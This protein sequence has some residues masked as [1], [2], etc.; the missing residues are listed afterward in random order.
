M[1][2]EPIQ[3]W[4]AG[5]YAYPLALGYRP[6]MVPYLHEEDTPRPC[7]L[8]VPGGGYTNVS[9]SEGELVAKRFYEAGFQTFLCSY[10]TN[11]LY[12]QP[13][14]DQPMQDLARAIRLLRSRPEA[15]RIDPN[16]IAV[17]GFSAGAHLCASVCVHSDEIP[18][19]R[20]GGISPRPDAA[21]LSYP[22]I[23]SGPAAHPGS[24][25]ALLGRDIFRREDAEAARLL[26]YYSVEKH[27]TRHTPPC[28]LWQT[29]EDQTVPVEN[30]LLMA[31]ALHRQGVRFAYHLFSQGPH[32][33][34]L[35]N[36]DWAARRFGDTHCFDQT[37]RILDAVRSGALPLPEDEKA[38]LLDKFAK[39]A[40]SRGTPNAEVMVWP[41]LAISW[42]REV[43]G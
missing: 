36:E 27:V 30:S 37:Q 43:L 42:L 3:L 23:T 38:V 19:A 39:A 10:T 21:I 25:Q 15:F 6:D 29:L 32:G 16:R 26:H 17:C 2:Y 31:S 7:I 14:M 40:A 28:F 24:F 4:E 35:A 34:S 22:V 11:P 13:L 20:Y 9:P 33:L 5:E 12:A 18:D 41:Q 1:K 8:V